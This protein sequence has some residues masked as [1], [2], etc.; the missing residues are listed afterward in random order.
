MFISTIRPAFKFT[1]AIIP[2]ARNQMNLFKR[3]SSEGFPPHTV[4]K[5]PALSP[6][7]THGNLGQW[8]KK[9]GDEIAPGDILVEIETD[10]AQM[11]FECQ[12][13]GFIAK[14]FVDAGAKDINVNVPICVLVEDKADIEK[15]ANFTPSSGAT[16]AAKKEEAPTLTP[17]AAPTPATPVAAAPAAG[18]IFASPLAKTLAAERGIDLA[19]VK[20]TGPDGRIVKED[21]ENY[22]APAASKAAPAS[23]PVAPTAQAAFTDVPLSNI[24]KV[25]ASRLAESKSTVPHY[26]MT[27]EINVDKVL[28]LREV[29]NKESNGKYKLSVNDFVIKASSLSLLDVPAV[30]SSWQGSFIRE[31]KNADIAVAVATDTGL[32]TPI[33]ASAETKGL[34]A[35]SN[36]VKS[37]AERARAGK[38]APQEYQGG[39]FTISNLGMYGI[40]HFTA[41][42]NPPHAAILAVGGIED[43]LVLDASS[44]KGFKATKVLKVTLSPDHRVVDGAVAAEWLQKFKAYL[45]NPLTMLL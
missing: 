23:T 43:K 10:K 32:I 3:F 30:N 11:D 22:K 4:I 39:T 45:E 16:P 8:H 5:M 9:I 21:I 25:I 44:E 13:E 14:I 31:Y 35:I 7:M 41:I 17:A 28:K 37:M 15:F 6:T 24:R 1:Q 12:D 42:I 33:V 20:G 34:S 2:L 27:Q 38:L 29:L 36:S 26:Y 18:R 19:T 40:Q